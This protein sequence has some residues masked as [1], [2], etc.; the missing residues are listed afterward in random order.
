MKIRMKYRELHT[1][2][3]EIVKC[4]PKFAVMRC[5]RRFGKTTMLEELAAYHSA[6]GKRVGWFAPSYKLIRPSYSRILTTLKP[7]KKSASKIEGIIETITGGCVEFWSLDD[8][9]AGRSRFYDLVIIDEASLKKKG[10]KEIW[11]QAIRPTLL[12]RGGSAIMAGTP[13]GIDDE[14]YFYL[15]CTDKDLGWV[16]FHAPTHS[17]PT[18]DK[19]SLANLEKENAPLVYQQEFLAQFIDWRGSAFFAETSMLVDG[20]PIPTPN[21]C[22]EVFAIIDTAVKDGLEH[23]G[24]AVLYVAR[25][26]IHGHPLILL[27]YDLIQIEGSLLDVWLPN[28]LARCEELARE[29]KARKGSLGAW[30]EDKASGIVLL[31]QATRLGLQAYP[32]TGDLTA[33]GKDGR[34][35]SISGYVH[36]G[37]VKFT[38]YAYD[39]VVNFKG[40]SKN[41]L[42]SQVCG[43]R[44]GM[45]TPHGMDLLDTF[46]YAVAIALGDSEGW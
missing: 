29:C 31:Q 42:L 44:M 26:T 45:K 17:N 28:V 18:L 15:A 10:L 21:I 22:D 12:D 43:Y 36:R 30:I 19:E 24:T 37:D 40:V 27:D 2:Q 38:Q 20:M 4:L 7:V 9:D 6:N 32:I 41:H 3:K 25:N 16:E 1:K 23:D 5:G 8:E 46:T 13:K 39:K 33:L 14:N 34:A 35:L 11:E